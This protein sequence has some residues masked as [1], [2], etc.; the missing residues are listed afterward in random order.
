MPIAIIRQSA[1]Y[2]Q[3][4]VSLKSLRCRDGSVFVDLDR[5]T[6]TRTESV[7]LEVIGDIAGLLSIFGLGLLVRVVF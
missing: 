7:W 5:R 3:M 4:K 1:R 2:C 6:E